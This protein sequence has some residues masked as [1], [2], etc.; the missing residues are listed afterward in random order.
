MS[1]P[2]PTRDALVTEVARGRTE[3][4]RLAERAQVLMLSRLSVAAYFE[5][6][7]QSLIRKRLLPDRKPAIRDGPSKTPDTG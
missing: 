6:P 2:P 3:K 5:R 4:R 7:A 1:A